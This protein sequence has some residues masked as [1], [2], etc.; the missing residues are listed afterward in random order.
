M[1]VFG[2]GLNMTTHHAALFEVALVILFGLPEG[3]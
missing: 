2:I 3:L 1:A